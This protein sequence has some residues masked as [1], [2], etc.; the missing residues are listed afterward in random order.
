GQVVERALGGA[1]D[2]IASTARAGD[3]GG[4]RCVAAGAVC[5][6]IPLEECV[7]LA[8]NIPGFD[9]VALAREVRER[10]GLDRVAVANDVKA[11]GEAEAR[12]GALSGADPALF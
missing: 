6:G 1:V 7:A 10:L 4:G 3:G 9:G 5:L 11:A 12:W 8:P 2:L